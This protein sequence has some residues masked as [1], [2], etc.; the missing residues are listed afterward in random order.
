MTDV[1][2]VTKGEHGSTIRAGSETIDVPAVK[3]RQI[4][5]PTG[6]GD[7]YRAGIIKGMLLDLPW[8][9]TGRMASLAATYVIEYYGTQNHQYTLEEFVERYREEFGSSEGVDALL[10]PKRR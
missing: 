10:A 7:A 1:V 8:E 3:P 6:V 2:I 4:A 5:D 9:I